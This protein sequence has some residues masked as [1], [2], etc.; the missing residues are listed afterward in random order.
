MTACP[1][2]ALPAELFPAD[3]W[4]HI[5][6]LLQM[7][8]PAQTLWLSG[9]L[10]A[11]AHSSEPDWPQTAATPSELTIAYGSETGNCEQLAR[12]LHD[13]VQRAGHSA[14]LLDLATLK[15]RQLR[16]V[17]TLWLIISTH[18]DGD[19]PLNAVDFHRDLFAADTLKLDTLR[20][21]VL[22]LGDRSYEHFCQTGID[23]DERLAAL[24]ATR[25]AER[26]ECDVDFE[27]AAQQWSDARLAALPACANAAV[28][29]AVELPRQATTQYSKQHPLHTEVLEQVALSAN[30]RP[31]GNYHLTVALREGSMTLEPGDAVGVFA[32]NPA[33]LVDDVLTL[34]DLPAHS[35]V[36]VGPKTLPLAEALRSARD[37]A[38]PTKKLLQHWAQWSGDT[39]LR[40]LS[41]DG[42]Q[43]RHWLKQHHL[44]DLLRTCPANVPSAQQLLDALRP[45]QP[46]LYDVANHVTADSDELELLVKRFDYR[47]GE[48]DYAG[49][50][51]HYLCDLAVGEPLR[52]YP[53][54]NARFA[55]PQRDEPVILVGYGTGLAPYRAYLQARAARG[56][57]NPCWLVMGEQCYEQDFL[58]QL[59]WQ[60]WLANGALTHLDPVFADDVPPRQ[61]GSV[62]A[63]S[64]RLR[65][66]LS[67]GAIVYFCGAKAVLS[68][69]EQQMQAAYA[70]V[71]GLGDADSATFW[72]SLAAEGR[73]KRNLY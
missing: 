3:Q 46:R 65:E 19:P 54:R 52:I 30:D 48:T 12:N 72:A 60:T 32:Q 22:A 15:V 29:T 8:D 20:Y 24:G 62:F 6:R 33:A 11:R 56:D 67:A 34:A 43:L 73:I 66:W 45:L 35:A 27:A 58:Y 16:K 69:C 44:L 21:A 59:D 41:E 10:A 9:Y 26:V 23:V 64:T 37:L 38:I 55:L 2:P 68:Q 31:R 13:A 17:T 70:D 36:T 50:A 5:D 53:H 63:G 28:S 7:L 14:R 42:A 18:G 40:A 71:A 1:P 57:D 61:L 51:S 49:I 4:Q 25:L 47:L 39:T